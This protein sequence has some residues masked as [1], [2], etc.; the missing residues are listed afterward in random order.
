MRLGEAHAEGL[1]RGGEFGVALGRNGNG[2]GQLVFELLN[3]V[4]GICQVPF[5]IG[6]AG[7][8]GVNV[9]VVHDLLSF[10]VEVLAGAVALA[11]VV[12][13]GAV[14]AKEDGAGSAK[15]T[16]NG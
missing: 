13:N 2:V 15:A 3:A 8:G 6:A 7:P 1:R 10:A 5:Q 9:E 14:G 16:E 4:P 12:S 11:S